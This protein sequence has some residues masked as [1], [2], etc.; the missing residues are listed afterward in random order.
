MVAANSRGLTL[1]DWDI[2]T[3]GM[4]VDYIIEHDNLSVDPDDDSIIRHATQD[5]YNR[6]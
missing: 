5:D 1:A 6:F 3:F 4:I 2:L